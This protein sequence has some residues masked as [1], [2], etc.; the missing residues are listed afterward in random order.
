MKKPELEIVKL[1]LK[2]THTTC[3]L[4]TFAVLI[5]PTS[6]VIEGTWNAEVRVVEVGAI[7]GTSLRRN[8]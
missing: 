4:K 2:Y 3:A 6:G 8:I 7:S 5:F 1:G